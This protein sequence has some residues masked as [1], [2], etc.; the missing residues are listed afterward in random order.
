MRRRRQ[1]TGLVLALALSVAI[2]GCATIVRGTH[3]DVTIRCPYPDAVMTLDGARI[4]TGTVDVE[5]SRDEDHIVT[6]DMPGCKPYRK[7][8]R[9]STSQ[10]GCF[11]YTLVVYIGCCFIIGLPLLVP[12]LVDA[13]DGSLEGL[14]PTDF[15]VTLMPEDGAPGTARPLPPAPR[16]VEQEYPEPLS[17]PPGTAPAPRPPRVTQAPPA[18][19]PQPPSVAPPGADAPAAAPK[20]SPQPEKRDF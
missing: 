6:V 2:S 7:T 9:S 19:A 1:R 3:Q 12:Y 8:L 20:E 15:T 13:L 5:L 10:G 16:P 18:P 17:P 11:V 4:G 14:D